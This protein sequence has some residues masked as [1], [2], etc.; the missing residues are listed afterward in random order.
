MLLVKRCRERVKAQVLPQLEE[1]QSKS[2]GDAL[3]GNKGK[4][5]IHKASRTEGTFPESPFRLR[6][7]AN[8]ARFDSL[9]L[10]TMNSYR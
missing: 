7:R 5:V 1:I 4:Q 2:Q 6:V 10:C 8:S 9:R 3:A